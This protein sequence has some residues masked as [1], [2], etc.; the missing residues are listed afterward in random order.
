MTLDPGCGRRRFTSVITA[1]KA[2]GK[3]AAGTPGECR[4]GGL[5]HWHLNPPAPDLAT[6]DRPRSPKGSVRAAVVLVL[7]R[8]CTVAQAARSTGA[9]PES[10]EAAAWA[11]VKQLVLERD[12]YTCLYSGRAA[13]DVHHRVRRGM[14]GTADPVIAFGL[15]NLVSLSRAAHDLAHKADDPEMADKGYRLETWQDPVMVPLVLFSETGPGA[16]VWLTADGS[17]VIRPQAAGAA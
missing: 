2:V 11:A 15:A 9:N 8:R 6:P 10:V 14:G 1:E 4:R 12:S 17:Y 5:V 16:H 3:G 7:D 13:V